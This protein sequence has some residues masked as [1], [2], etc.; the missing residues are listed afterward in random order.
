MHNSHECMYEYVYHYIY[1]SCVIFI[2]LCTLCYPKEDVF[3]LIWFDYSYAF[4]PSP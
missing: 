2:G 4:F 3:D 1:M